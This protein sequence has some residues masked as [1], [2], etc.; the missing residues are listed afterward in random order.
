MKLI[1][2]YSKK[3]IELKDDINMYVCGPTVYSEPHIGNM[4]PIIIFDIMAKVM[5]L[6]SRVKFI[7]NITDVDDKIINKAKE[8]NVSENVISEKYTK[9]Y[10]DLL[11]KLNIKTVT[12]MPKVTD[13]IDGIIRYIENLISKGHA[14]ESNGSVYFDVESYDGYAKLLDI[15]IDELAELESNDDKKTSKDFAL[16]KKTTIGVNWESPWS[17]GRPGWHTECSYFIDEYFG[18]DGL[19]L[20]GGGIDLRFPHHTNEMAQCETN[21]SKNH[22]AK[23]WS[24]VGHINMGEE[25]MS[26][27]LGNIVTASDFINEHGTNVMRMLM[28][29]T[30]NLKPISLNNDAIDNSKQIINKIFNALKKSLLAHA[31]NGSSKLNLVKPSGEFVDLLKNDLDVVN[32]LTFIFEQIKK[33]NSNPINNLGTIEELLANLDLIGIQFEIKYNLLKD[34]IKKY[35]DESDYEKLDKLREEIIR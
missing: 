24:Y 6:D 15:D 5:S 14:Y 17:N 3:E 18:K 23:V 28:Y 9:S 29:Q 20:H 26:K 7:H 32:S 27:S 1:D 19:D 34:D 25:K 31:I 2:F 11:D 8:L 16:W 33:I 12:H 35:K 4:R 22:T 13:H 21:C 10:L 30:K